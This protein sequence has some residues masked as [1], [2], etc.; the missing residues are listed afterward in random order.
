MTAH[1]GSVAAVAVVALLTSACAARQAPDVRTASAPASASGAADASAPSALA[2]DVDRRFA[3]ATATA[4]WS[5]RIERADTGAVLV[6]RNAGRLLIPASNM[7]IVTLA[8]AATRLGWDFRFQTRLHATGARHGHALRG[9]LVV[10]GGADPTIGRG[11]DP[12]ATFRDWAR[13][14]RAQGIQRI[15]G[16]L[17]G[18]PTRFGED[19][20]GGAWSWDDL[21]Y[22]YA[23]KYSGLIFDENVVRLRVQPGPAP[24]QPARI[25]LS[26]DVFEFHVRARVETSPAGEAPTL[27]VHRD[28]QSP[29]VEVTGS[30]PH[31]GP[32]VERTL[33]VDDP[34]R[35]FLGVL[36]QT[37]AGEG[38]EVRGRTRVE[39][40]DDTALG[41]PLI[42]HAS[43]PLPEV[44]RRL[45]KVSQN[46]YG[47]V[48]L[49]ALTADAAAGAAPAADARRA[50][51]D[52]IGAIGVPTG[53]VQG[54]DGSGLS[55]RDFVTA[56]ALITLLRHMD[57]EPHREPFRATLP[58]AGRD[59][60]L[61]RRFTGNPCEGRLIAKTGTL[62]H[63]R[64]LSGYITSASGTPYV[65]AVIANNF[66]VPAREIDA[67]VE[68]ALGVL[69]AS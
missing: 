41:A 5:V 35:F 27:A 3:A 22:G 49:R 23:A 20:L 58:V 55:R 67:I 47:E 43:P 1:R 45:M 60:T 8:A 6:D 2:T 19:W 64:A 4:L 12:L 50:L 26:P 57:V 18:D 53:S 65:F 11:P 33:A 36:R 37:L 62:A 14:L 44:A 25:A 54:L 46:L 48:L 21:P 15:D 34:A 61:A 39:R 30:I 56:E 10:V 42:V 40:T 52:A 59:G 13:Q 38:I 24:G 69:C 63:A 9:D 32:P 16:D 66:I 28:G 68:D 51:Q 7:K 31:G 17:I 29:V